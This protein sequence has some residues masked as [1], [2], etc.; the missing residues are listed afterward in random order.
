MIYIYITRDK[1][2]K[3]NEKQVKNSTTKHETYTQNI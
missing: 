3:K 2:I 1:Y